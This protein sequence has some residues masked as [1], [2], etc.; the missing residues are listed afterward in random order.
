MRF[1]DAIA[2]ALTD[3]RTDAHDSTSTPPIPLGHQQ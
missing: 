2:Y 3:N 1:D